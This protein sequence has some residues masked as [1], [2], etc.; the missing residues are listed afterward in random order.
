M[1]LEVQNFSITTQGMLEPPRTVLSMPH[2]LHTI[3]LSRAMDGFFPSFRPYATAVIA[4]ICL[5]SSQSLKNVCLDVF[6]NSITFAMVNSLRQALTNSAPRLRVFKVHGVTPL[7]DICTLPG[8]LKF[9]EIIQ[10]AS[11]L[12]EMDLSTEM[13]GF[14]AIINALSQ[15]PR[16][17]VVSLAV[18]GHSSGRIFPFD[19]VISLINLSTSL[20]IFMLGKGAEEAW[21]RGD[22]A[23]QGDLLEA[24]I[25]AGVVVKYG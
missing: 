22:E 7:L 15:H 2:R 5:A 20:E 17:R 4:D 13:S 21:Y 6:D 23:K 8:Y 1:H 3:H 9:S 16:L 19:Q 14:D 18:E 25:R 11:S 24:A 10:Q 12:E